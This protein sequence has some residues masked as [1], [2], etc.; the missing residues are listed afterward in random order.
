MALYATGCGFKS[1]WG[2]N[3]FNVLY[4]SHLKRKYQESSLI[5]RFYK[6]HSMNNSKCLLKCSH[7]IYYDM[8]HIGMSDECWRK[9]L[10]NYTID[11]I[12]LIA[13]LFH[14]MA[15][16]VQSLSFGLVRHRLWVQ[17]S[18]GSQNFQCVLWKPFHVQVA[19]IK[20]NQK[21]LQN[22][23]HKQFKMSS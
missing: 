9:R 15:S 6:I 12:D 20:L 22:S 10:Y 16:V 18:V 5:R 1:L 23:K 13:T 7:L 11:N 21:I 14:T 4:E 8:M 19:G 17:I 3:I 2:H